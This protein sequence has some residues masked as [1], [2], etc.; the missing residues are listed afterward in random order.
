MKKNDS[1]NNN[2]SLSVKVKTWNRDTDDLYDF[3]AK[4]HEIITQQLTIKTN[5][6]LTVDP[7]NQVSAIEENYI[8]SLLRFDHVKII[9]E[10]LYK[11]KP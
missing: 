3:E 8:H 2:C 9:G 1:S 6:I 11:S 7:N 4:D 10:I 5:T